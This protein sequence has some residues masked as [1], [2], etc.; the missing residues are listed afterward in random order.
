MLAV[1]YPSR[2]GVPGDGRA[3]RLPRD[4][5]APRGGAGGL[6]ADRDDGRRRL[7]S[8]HKAARWQ[9]SADALNATWSC[10]GTVGCHA[11][12]GGTP[13]EVGSDRRRDDGN[14]RLT[15]MTGTVLIV[16]LAV[17]GVTILRIGQLIWLHLFLGLLLLGPL[18]VK[19]GSTGYRFV[20]Y[21]TGDP[22]Y[23]EKG[24]PEP[25]AALIA[26]MVVAH[27]AG[28]LRQRDRADG[29]RSAPPR[30]VPAAPQG[31]LLRLAGIHRGSTSSPTCRRFPARC[32]RRAPSASSPARGPGASGR[33]HGARRCASWRA[34][35]WPCC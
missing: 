26:P 33:M 23:R 22:A 27:D 7:S 19:L 32:V 24:P 35:C 34:R 20:R 3:I 17:L 15:A 14:E 16:L 9:L 28:G 1:Q 2:A 21:Y 18:A 6:A 25:A 5:R 10:P 8:H 13:S 11:D 12:R 29:R 4:P 31:E 30:P